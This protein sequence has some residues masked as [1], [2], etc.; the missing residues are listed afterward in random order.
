M[1]NGEIMKF[2]LI[3]LLIFIAGCTNSEL[4]EDALIDFKVTV[5]PSKQIKI[6]GT[7]NL[8]ENTILMISIS[9]QMEAGFSREEKVSVNSNGAFSSI[10]GSPTSNKIPDGLFTASILMPYARV[11]PDNVK[12]IIGFNGEKLTG[13]LVHK[14]EIGTTIQL[15]TEFGIGKHPHESQQKRI[16]KIQTLIKNLEYSLCHHLEQLLKFK[17]SKKFRDNG[18]G[19]GG[20]D[21]WLHNL[22]SLSNSQP[23]GANPIPLELRAAPETLILLGMEY[24]REQHDTEYSEKTLQELKQLINYSDYLSNK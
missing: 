21:I 3:I 14:D 5:L 2:S 17:D 4:N 23:K 11:Q 18:F 24:M 6:S 9:E 16:R 8:P 19:N 10:L 7:T 15:A 20:Y 12:K 1:P 22:R 13:K